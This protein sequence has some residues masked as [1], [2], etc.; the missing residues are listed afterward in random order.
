VRNLF[1]A[2]LLLCCASLSRA[3]GYV[4]VSLGATY[5]NGNGYASNPGAAMQYAIHVRLEGPF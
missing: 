2:F 4:A 5:A 3:Q 1:L